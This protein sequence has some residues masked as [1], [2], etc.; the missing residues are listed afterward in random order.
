MALTLILP[1]TNYFPL[2]VIH[3]IIQDKSILQVKFHNAFI[4]LNIG[5]HG[6]KTAGKVLFVAS[7]G[8]MGGHFDHQG[9]D[10]SSI[11]NL[12][13]WVMDFLVAGLI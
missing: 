2:L 5:V 13:S 10:T 7:L 11:N 6:D 9:T 12:L 3:F 8:D 1:H 4:M